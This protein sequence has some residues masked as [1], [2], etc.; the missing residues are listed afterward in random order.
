MR[1]QP[2]RNGTAPAT[3]LTW[4]D[5]ATYERVSKAAGTIPIATYVMDT[6]LRAFEKRTAA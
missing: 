3:K 4:K 6:F 2:K 1:K 5:R